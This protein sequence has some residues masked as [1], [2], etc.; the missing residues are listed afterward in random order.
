MQPDQTGRTVEVYDTT[1]R[2]GTQGEGISLSVEDK[3][4]VTRLLDELGVAY[5]EGGWPGS[6]P[7]DASYFRDVR[8]IPLRHARVAAFGMT[9]RVGGDPA[10][11]ANIQALLDAE[12]PV[13]TVVGKTSLLHVYD[14]LRTTPEEN[15]RI[16][17]DSLAHLKSHGRELIYDAEHFFDGYKLDAAYTLQTLRA[18]VDGGATTVVLCDTN[19][20]AMP[21]DVERITAEVIAALPGVR[22]GI[23]TH[24]DG[25]LAVAN[26]LAAVLQGAAQVQGTMNGFGERCGNANLCA[27]VPDLEL[28]MGYCC[29]PEGGLVHLTRIA[30]T[31]SEIANMTP[32]NQAAFVGKSAFAH[33]GGMHAAAVRRNVDSYQHIDPALVGNEMRILVSD[34]SGQGNM[35][36]KAEE[37]GLDLSS[38]QAKNVVARIKELENRGFVFEGAEASVAM[39]MQRQQPGYEPPFELIDFMVV[40][41]NRKGRGMFAEAT[42][43]VRVRG[44]ELHTVAEGNGPV[45]AL[46]HALRKA[47]LP[48]YPQLADFKLADYKVR[49]LD[50]QNGTAATTRVLIDTQNGSHRWS[51]VGASANIIEASWLA[52]ADSVEYGL[53]KTWQD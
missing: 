33:K 28:K 35:L 27:I 39:L 7:K 5:I 31:V 29:L 50:G 12:T 10:H 51:T 32:N 26:T 52:L 46:D 18:A 22:I 1:L 17:H 37:Y 25:E 36:S 47:L 11:D 43:K 8:T 48:A 24:N 14:V 21:W 15:L 6:N 49:I 53:I 40:V 19:G 20:G 41:E 42:V 34:L 45:D 23:H 16:I 9:C 3:L 4:R 2:D 38:D 44:E 13:V 30:R